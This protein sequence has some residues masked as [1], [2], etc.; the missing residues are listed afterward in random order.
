MRRASGAFIGAGGGQ[1]AEPIVGFPHGIEHATEQ[2]RT[3]LRKRRAICGGDFAA[4]ME[5]SGLT[6]RHEQNVFSTETNNLGVD[7]KIV[8]L[9]TESAEFAQADIGTFGLDDETRNTGDVAEASHRWQAANLGA[10][11]FDHGYDVGHRK[12]LSA[13]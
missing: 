3:D 1:Q 12:W 11:G 13:E 7:R 10:E 6:E 8:A 2:A 9:G 5:A 4:G